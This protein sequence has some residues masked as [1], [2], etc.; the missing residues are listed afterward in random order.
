MNKNI[1]AYCGYI[2]LISLVGY[3]LDTTLQS[4]LAPTPGRN[5]ACGERR[6]T[7]CVNAL[8]DG[9]MTRRGRMPGF[10]ADRYFD[11]RCFQ[12]SVASKRQI[13]GY[14]AEEGARSRARDRGKD[15]EDGF[16]DCGGGGAVVC[17]IA[18]S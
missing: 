10:D 2:G 16:R 6:A 12:K 17:E 5:A 1:A 9:P 15:L 18:L 11:A 7:A 14:S 3:R 13:R 8:N 4:G